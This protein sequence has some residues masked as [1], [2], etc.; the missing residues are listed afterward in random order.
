VHAYIWNRAK[1]LLQSDG[2][3]FTNED[4]STIL[5][6]FGPNVSGTWNVAVLAGNEIWKS[7]EMDL[8]NPFQREAFQ[9]GDIPSGIALV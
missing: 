6:Q 5:W 9:R 1:G 8:G 4:G 3:G 7:F 2:E